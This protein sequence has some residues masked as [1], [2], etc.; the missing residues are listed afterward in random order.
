MSLAAQLENEVTFNL[1]PKYYTDP[2]VLDL[3]RGNVLA[4]TWQYAGHESQ[5]RNKG[6]YFAFE[7]AGQ[8]L[9]CI[10][11]RN[12]VIQAFF[13]V[14]QHRAHELV[15][16]TGNKRAIT[17]PYHAWTYGL[18]GRLRNGP[19][20]SAVPGFDI[21]NISL[22]RVRLENFH[23]FLFVNL[24]PDAAPMESWFPNAFEE[25]ADYVPNIDQLQPFLVTR[26]VENCNWK[27][28]IE[29]YSECYHCPFNHKAIST[30][31]F[32]PE[33]YDIQPQGYC[34]RH[35]TESQTP[36]NM[37]YDVDL[38]SSRNADKYSSWFLWPMFSFQVFPG[39]ILN[40]Y[41]WREIDTDYV[42]VHRGWYSVN[43]EDSPP[44]RQLAKLDRETTVEE[45]I[46]LVESVQRGMRNRG[47]RPGPLVVDPAGGLN[48]EHSIKLLQEWMRAGI[49]PH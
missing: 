39:N 3:E 36:E 9:F 46:R 30:G 6:D 38:K 41:S 48:S 18:D 4:R 24:D 25:I 2:E 13:N 14:C 43:G 22:T 15:R 37:S 45:D 42:E 11:G 10:R 26:I 44:I 32:K 16:G 27:V 47:Y 20:I 33:S 8:S 29:N 23:G 49:E 12:S 28:A 31:V 7:I 19:N 17:C 35:T 5:I 34:L 40:T 1:H 21:S